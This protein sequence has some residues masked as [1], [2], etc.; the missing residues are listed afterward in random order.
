MNNYKNKIMIVI[1]IVGIIF[2]LNNQKILAAGFNNNLNLIKD[3]EVTGEVEEEFIKNDKEYLNTKPGNGSLEKEISQLES[4]LEKVKKEYIKTS[5]NIKVY[6]GNTALKNNALRTAIINRKNLIKSAGSFKYDDKSKYM[7]DREYERE[8]R[9]KGK[10]NQMDLDLALESILTVL[11]NLEIDSSFLENTKFVVSPYLIDGINGY[12]VSRSNGL[13][14]V[15]VSNQTMMAPAQWRKKNIKSTTLHEIGHVFYNGHRN[16][17]ASKDLV[18][19]YKVENDTTQSNSI[20]RD[21]E[22]WKNSPSENFAEDFRIY[23]SSKLGDKSF[24]PLKKKTNQGY[25][26][27]EF[28]DM[29]STLID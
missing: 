19:K 11:E 16:K 3:T 26:E 15:V 17:I 22:S 4:E 9:V 6:T 8:S 14:T 18:S 24:E 7:M 28:A 25:E 2:L 20:N 29:M 13:N 23:T 12:T 21:L 1:F 10:I 5:N 27:K